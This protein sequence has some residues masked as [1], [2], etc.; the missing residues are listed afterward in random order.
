MKNNFSRRLL[1]LFLCLALIAGY[2][3]LAASAA[4]AEVSP[5]LSDSAIVGTFSDP[6]TADS[7]ESM[8]GTATDGN[9]YAGRVW[10]DKSVYKDGDI[11]TLN[12]S[13]AP[14]SSFEVNLKD[15]E[16]FQI[17]FSALGSTMTSKKTI[18]SSGP[19]DVVLILDDSTSM[20][21][22]ISEN[23]TRLE[24]LIEASNGLLSDLLNSDDIRIGIVAYN[25][26]AI[27]ILPFGRYEN[28][29]ELR[30]RNNKF[31]FD[32]NNRQDKGGTIQA[33]DEDGA[34]LYNNTD[35]YARGTNTQA[36]F[37]LGMRMLEGATDKE[38]RAPVAILLTDGA[39]NTAA[40][41]TFYN[42]EG[43]SPRSIF[44]GS[45]VPSGVALTT[46]LTASFRRAS[47]ENAYGKAPMVY[48]IGV[49]IAGDAAA[50]AII[51]PGS[52]TDGFNNSNSSKLITDAYKLYLSWLNGNTIEREENYY[53][54]YTFTADHGYTRVSNITLDDIKN[55][56]NYVDTYYP[57]SS[58][59]LSDT[60]TQIYEELSSGV[61]NPISSSTSVDGATGV[62]NTPLIYVDFIGQHMEIKEIQSVTLF[63]ASYGVTKNADG[64][65]TVAEAKGTNPTTNEAWNTAEDILIKIIEQADGTQKLEIRINQEILPIIM[66]R[67]V[68]ETVGS[69]TVSTIT[70]LL[71]NPLRVYYTVGIDSDILLP[72][73]KIDVSKL[74]GYEYI[75]DAEGTVSFYSNRFGVK[76]AAVNGVVTKGDAHVGFKPSPENRYYYHQ[77]NQGIFTS[78][79]DINT[80]KEISI[81]ENNQYGIVWDDSKYALSWM[82]YDEY[83]N[84][85]LD[86]KVYTYVTYYHP[87]PDANDA[88]NAAEEVT[89]LV[90]TDWGY[91]KESASF[92]DNNAKKYVNYDSTNGYIT[93]DIGVAIDDEALVKSTINAYKSKNPNADIYAVLGVGSVRTSRLHNMT[94]D[95]AENTTGTA[96]QYYSPEYLHGT[97]EIEEHNDNDVVVW[98]GNNGI[99]TVKID[100]GIALTKTVTEAIGNADDTYALTVT[101]PAGVT[102][103]PAV[104]DA[105]GNAVNSTYEN[106]VLTVSVK[107]G[108]TVF[109]TGIPGGT[110]CA[111]G[112]IVNGDYYIESKTDSVIVPLVSEALNGKAQFV[113]ATVTNAPNKYGN[114][115]ITK[116]ITSDH[117]VPESIRDTGFDIIVSLGSALAGKTFSVMDSAHASAFDVTADSLGNL[118]FTIKDRQTIEVLR[119]PEGTAVTVTE[120][121][122]DNHFTVSYRTRNHSGETADADNALVIPADGNATAVVLNHYTPS[123]VLVDLDIEII[124]N[125]A[126]AT[127]ADRLQGGDF[128]FAVDKYSVAGK[129]WINIANGSV[130]YGANE[131]GKKTVTVEDVLN[132]ETYTEAGTYSY[133]VSEIKGNVVNISYD[134]VI[135]TFDVIVTDNGGSL[136]AT[137][138]GLNSSEIKNES[139]D[140]A[141]DYVVEFTN[142]YETAPISMDIEKT[143]INNSGDNTVTAQGFKFRSIAVDANGTP[144]DPNAPITSTNLIISDAAGIARI[145]GVY[146]KAQI[147]THYYIV[148]E[149][150]DGRSGWTYSEA[151]YFITVVV[152]EDAGGKISAEMTIE[153]F[154][155]AARNEKAPTV[156]DNNK[157]NLYF[158]NTY[159]PEDTSIDLDGTVSKVLTGMPLSADQFTFHVYADGDR[160]SPLLTGSNNLNGLVEFV[161]FDGVLTFDKIGKYEYDIAE[162]IPDGAEYDH[163][164]GKYVLNGMY[165]DAT[166]YDLVVEVTND[167]E[168]G[169]L[170]AV[171]YFE[172]AVTSTVTFHNSY[173]AESTD[174]T[175]SGT[176]ILHG[177]AL[178]AEEFFFELY[179]G[180]TLK[181]TVSNNADGSFSFNT[182]TYTEAGVYTYTVKEKAGTVAGISYDGANAPI[183]VVVTVTDSNGVLIAS[184]SI[185]NSAISFTNT[186]TAKAASVTF[187]G[188]KTLAGADLADNSFSFKLYKTNNSFSITDNTA[189]LIETAQNV[190]GAFSF[191]K[192]LST[193]GTYFFVI[194]EDASAPIDSV[195]YDRT[196]Y[197]FV[198]QVT[199]IGDGQ[200]KASV[201]NV[202]TKEYTGA[203]DSITANVSFT[204]AT[205]DEV[206][207][208]EVYL[209]GNIT[210][211]IDGTK[212]N[213][214]DTL[215][216]FITYTNYTGEIVVVDIMDTIPDHTTYVNGSASHNGT[217][218]GTHLNWILKVAKDESVTV[219]FDVTVNDTEAIVANT[220]VIRDGVN[221]YF[222]NEVVNHTV[223]NSLDK[224]V[225]SPEDDTISIDGEKV[226][227]GDELLYKITFTNTSPEAIDLTITDMIPANTTY[228]EGSADNN[229]AFANNVIVWTVNGLPAWET[230]TVSFKVTVNEGIGAV[231]IEN[232]ATATDGT[233]EYETEWVTNYTVEDEVEKNVFAENTDVSIDG[234][235][236]YN[237]DILTYAIAYTN[238]A[239]EAATVTITD[240]VPQ[241]TVY[242]DGSA[243]N[244]GVYADGVITWTLEAEAGETVTVTFKVEVS[245]TDVVT[246]ENTADVVEG[247]NTYTTNK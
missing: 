43:Q 244:A 31:Y 78:I 185:E 23:T 200:L 214:G 114:L 35:G 105:N 194:V 134:R 171:C 191:E 119:I 65:Y 38:G 162:S 28:G 113:S 166:I 16:A 243:D 93:S 102:A 136:V 85:A 215:T 15:D 75:N 143:V 116:E 225:F 177:R 100:T 216:Y 87:T 147:G 178:R 1:S 155:D 158:T 164:T 120:A 72:G 135:Y 172:D 76:N 188:T 240:T 97:A 2:I 205:F 86:E 142:T 12:S 17:I 190:N 212:V 202:T 129:E 18:R 111:I 10:V 11:V 245:T 30:V 24:K 131:Y 145:S 169:K 229:G 19:L 124:K 62:D 88:A 9:R 5:H 122:P 48:G 77:A 161:D 49:D 6:G 108:E 61:F 56:I 141:L 163:A 94:V 51:N 115:F 196:Q 146:T 22:I 107:A 14:G 246:I 63:G 74:Q 106:N 217:Y 98:L 55:N 237:V 29:V 123:P 207:E 21:D 159:D 52:K 176:K 222:T 81:N 219:S 157:G 247:K 64:T 33:F 92:Y 144:L 101:V 153:P 173:K 132:G 149:E 130:S 204:N 70:E 117:A 224:D 34:L 208:K 203:A 80:D 26:D 57:V 179:E 45:G 181:E 110:E 13:G 186:Y 182:I 25:Y 53:G 103:S 167:K 36:G 4:N 128:S 175:I 112:E 71:Q 231:I 233:N 174:Y 68:S 133:R 213:A 42:I 37:D 83:L 50:N 184:A 156:T 20:D 91:L 69:S 99:L 193:A 228:V 192:E 223:D 168:S 39:A 239:D 8:M 227:E 170:T 242:V 209:A 125:F 58:A 150:N 201:I 198:V 238:T 84:T 109:V 7:W 139:G 127:V 67:T 218:A 3:P 137:V 54:R 230:V 138:V 79:T 187:N 27:Q 183:T 241:Y 210:T 66:E 165:Y 96:V 195:V 180:D 140:S 44:T 60:F 234:K 46:L 59:E 211:E 118:S 121:T 73:E 82:T 95:K 199:D 148:Y 89:Y 90:Y 220:A 232:Q 126:D 41:N 189:E 236:V 197:R 40:Q 151:Q 235:K 47:V 152:S 206:T 226:Y 154:N 32:E 104:V 160:T 221:T